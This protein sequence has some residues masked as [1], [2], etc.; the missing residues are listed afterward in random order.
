MA[1]IAHIAMVDGCMCWICYNAAY[2][3]LKGVLKHMA[4]THAFDPRF[5]VCCGIQG[6][7]NFRKSKIIVYQ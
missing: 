7:K 5:S 4:L 6:C 2:P 3:S 1:C